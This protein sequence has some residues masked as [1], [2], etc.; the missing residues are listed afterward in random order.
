MPSGESPIVILTAM[1]AMLCMLAGVRDCLGQQFHLSES[2]EVGRRVENYDSRHQRQPAHELGFGYYYQGDIMLPKPQ[3]QERLSVGEEYTST[4]WPNAIVPY[5]IV[6]NSFT[7]NQIYMI[8]R[9]MNVFHAK[10]CVRFVPRTAQTPQFVRIT[11]RPAGC[12]A[13]IGRNLD[14]EQN[15]MNLQAPGCLHGGTPI[16]EMMHTLGFLHEVSRP[17]RDQYIYVNRSAL[18]PQYQT[19]S[20]YNTN[21]AKYERNVETYNI[22][23]NYGSIMHYTRYAGARDRRYPVLVNL[24]SY[25]ED[26]FGNSTL[27]ATDIESIHFRYC[28]NASGLFSLQPFNLRP[29]A[30]LGLRSLFSRG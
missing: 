16:H 25:D 15:V 6:P 1:L 27:S 10:T 20:F 8:E 2:S 30:F 28:R 24:K 14:N 19:D 22:G 9:A 17:D 21:F 3:N 26:D 5:Y 23:Y 13:S 12:Y 18:E 4:I 7:S 11:N 29:T